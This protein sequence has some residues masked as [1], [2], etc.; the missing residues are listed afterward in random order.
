M[1]YYAQNST[2]TDG[3]INI[4]LGGTSRSTAA[5]LFTPRLQARNPFSVQVDPVT[6]EVEAV[7]QGYTRAQAG[8]TLGGPIKKDKTFYFVSFETTR[9][10]ETGFTNIGSSNFGLV[11]ATTPVIPGVTLMLTPAQRDFVSSPA[12]LTA[13]G[14][15]QVAA[16]LFA[17]AGSGSSVGLDGIDPGLVATFRGVPTPPG[18]R[19]PILIDVCRR[20]FLAPATLVSL[21]SSFVPLRQL[22]GNYPCPKDRFLFARLD[23]QWN[24]RNSS[25][26]RSTF[27]RRVTGIQVNAQNQNFGQNAGSRTSLQQTR[28]LVIVAACHHAEAI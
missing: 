6:G 25:F 1:N 18:S 13:P 14:G 9:R 23:H 12:V 22:I 5:W 19:F 21:P 2:A 3:I 8:A 27:R 20:I 26:V 4:V 7:K 10:Q 15:A 28:D 17:L 24:E 11:P 16:A